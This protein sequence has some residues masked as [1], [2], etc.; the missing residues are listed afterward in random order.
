MPKKVSG[1]ADYILPLGLIGVAVFVLYKMG[2]FNGTFTGTGGNNAATAANTTATWT[3]AFNTSAQSVPQSLPDTTLNSMVTEMLADAN[4]NT[5]IFS[6]STYQAD[7]VTQ[8]SNLD[9]ITDLYRLGM[10][11]GTRAVPTS[12]FNL[13]NTLDIDCAQ[14]DLGAFLKVTLTADQLAQVNQ[15]LAGNGINYTFT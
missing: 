10:L 5:S 11:W 4:S 6:G 2:I 3:S 8:M 1:A 12:D 14:L 15:D 9:N 7:I 13:C